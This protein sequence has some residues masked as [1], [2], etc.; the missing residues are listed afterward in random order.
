M[1]DPAKPLILLLDPDQDFLDAMEV[2]GHKRTVEIVAKPFSGQNREKLEDIVAEC[3]PDIVVLNLDLDDELSFGEPVVEILR[4]PL[5]IPP[6]VMGTTARDAFALKSRAY[7]YGI[8]DV[9]IRPFNPREAWLR[10]DVLLRTRRLQRQLDLATRKLSTL[11]VSLQTSNRHLEEMTITD[12]LTGLN[13]MRYMTQYLEKQ[14][15]V[16]S[17]HD[18]PFSVMMIDLDHFKQVND[19]NDH[20]VGSDTIRTVGQII[21]AAT[22]GSDIK[23]RY[24]GDEY[25]VAMPETDGDSAQT[26]AERIREAIRTCEFF[27]N[28]GAPFTVTASIGLACFE[29]ARHTNYKEIIKDA[30]FAMYVAKQR[31]RDQVV[32]YEHGK[33]NAPEGSSENYDE[34]QSSVLSEIEK[35]VK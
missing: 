33:T 13:N 19:K 8:D 4:V 7:H 35:V 18:R 28:E 3:Y 9:L 25:I 23:A 1:S 14:F 34:T 17:R 26:V 10:L 22:R 32:L 11:N 5:P 29:R 30:D 12:E 20:L 27:G 2:E 24:G 16:F 15:Q 6:I 21:H 31:G